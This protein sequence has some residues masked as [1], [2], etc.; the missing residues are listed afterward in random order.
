MDRPPRQKRIEGIPQ[1]RSAHLRRDPAVVAELSLLVQEERFRRPPRVEKPGQRSL[2]IAN[3]RKRV[4]M[5]LRM[6]SDLVD[7]LRPVAVDGDEEDP[8]RAVR[9]DQITQSVVVVVRIRT[10][11]RPEDQDNRAVPALR[12]AR[13]ERVALDCLCGERGGDVSDLEAGRGAAEKQREER[14]A[15]GL[16]DGP[17]RSRNRRP[18]SGRSC[19]SPAG[20]KSPSSTQRPVRAESCGRFFPTPSFDTTRRRRSSRSARR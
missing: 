7:R 3:H 17:T 14:G 9:R 18:I 10:E 4:P 19:G 1:V 5:L 6:D 8:F 15:G 2:R 13:G 16:A 11:R 20:G 12:V